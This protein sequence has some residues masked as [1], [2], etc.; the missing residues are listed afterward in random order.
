MKFAEVD[1]CADE[2]CGENG[3]CQPELGG[4]NCDCLPGWTGDVCS[5]GMVQ[6]GAKLL[7]NN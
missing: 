3:L 6:H 7:L 2:P 5:T 4:F 1:Y